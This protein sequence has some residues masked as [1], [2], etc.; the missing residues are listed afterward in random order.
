M[1]ALPSTVMV[2]EAMPGE[3]VAAQVIFSDSFD[4]SMPFFGVA[5][6]ATTTSEIA[7][8]AGATTVNVPLLVELPPFVSVV[9]IVYEWLPAVRVPIGQE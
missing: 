2:C 4:S 3:L 1:I 7:G 8:G 5:A 6:S 9:V